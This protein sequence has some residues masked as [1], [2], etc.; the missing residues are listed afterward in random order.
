MSDEKISTIKVI[1]FSGK[2]VDWQVWS[3]K[4]LARSRRKGYKSILQGKAVV[5]PDCLSLVSIADTDSRK[6]K[7]KLRDLNEEAYEDLILSINGDS[8]SGRV[9]FQIV[10]GSKTSAIKDGDAREAW[11]RLEKK[12]EKKTAPS[13]LILKKQFVNSKLKSWKNDPDVWLTQLEDLQLQII[14]AGGNLSDEDV[15]EQV[16]NNLPRSYDIVTIPMAKRIGAR[17]NPLT[18]NELRD[19]LN[20]RFENLGGN[21]SNDDGNSDETALFAGG[22]KGKCHNCGKHGHKSRDCPDKNKNNNNNNSS[23]GFNGTCNYCKEKGHKIADCPK[24]KRKKEREHANVATDGN[25]DATTNDEE[26]AL[27][28][29][30]ELKVPN[31]L[32]LEGIE[33]ANTN[34]FIGDTGASCHMTGSLAGMFDLQDIQESITVGNGQCTKATKIGKKRGTVKTMDGKQR[35][36]VLTNVK[37]VPDL[38]PYNLFSITYALSNG[39]MIGNKGET[40]YLKKGDFVLTFDKKIPTKTGYVAAVDIAPR[41]DATE[42]AAPTLGRDQPININRFHEL[43]GHP[44]LA[45]TKLVAKYYGVKLTG[46]FADCEACAK[47]KARQKN[48]PKEIPAENKSKNPGERL[49]MDISSIKAHSF[50]G[51]KYWL[52]IMDEAT[53]YCWSYFLKKKSETKTHLTA[54]I[55]HLKETLKYQTKFVRCDNAGENM[56]AEQKCLKDGLGVT[57]EYTAP[58]TPQQNGRVERKVATLYGRVRSLLNAACLSTEF[59]KGLW[60][61]CAR[62]ATYLDNLNSDTEDGAPRYKHLFGKDDDAFPHLRKFGEI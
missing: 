28:F 9:A 13:R 55:K 34:V 4:F 44:S 40:I 27:A 1:P 49:F 43:L 39:F 33:K 5:P 23:G 45:K 16:I 59:R 21:R 26:V 19:E 11:T 41:D 31:D 37:Y 51:A 32:A 14:N 24:L 57:F 15:M 52:L 62:T 29:L 60:A 30:D 42:L 56:R 47:A 10:R 6:E 61:E 54:L 3:E 18:I 53:G 7:Q 20:L 25:E 12:Y 48:I 17:S 2:Q 22:F 46:K 58:N 50:G 8:E 35:D 38:A 36:I